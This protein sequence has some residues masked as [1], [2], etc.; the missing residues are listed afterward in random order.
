MPP[1]PSGDEPLSGLEDLFAAK[2]DPM[3]REFATS[4]GAPLPVTESHVSTARLLALLTHPETVSLVPVY[5]AANL[6]PN[7][8]PNVRDTCVEGSPPPPAAMSE[9]MP[10]LGAGEVSIGPVNAT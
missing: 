1:C 9:P 5:A 10:R 6:S 7:C 4:G 2:S 8:S 3:P